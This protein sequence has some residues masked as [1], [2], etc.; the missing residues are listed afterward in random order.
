MTIDTQ[1]APGSHPDLPPPPSTVGIVGWLR[2]NLFS[3]TTNTLITV[4]ALYLLYLTLPPVFSWIFFKADFIGDSR[5]SCDSG[6][7]C[8]VFINARLSQ[9]IYGFYPEAERWRVD[10]TFY[11]LIA[12]MIPM[13]INSFRHKAWLGAFILFI[14]PV[15]GFYLLAGGSFGLATV[16][17]SLWGGLSLTLII[18]I[19]GI[20][21][22]FPI[23]LLL[24]LG[25][26]SKM[27][28][29]SAFCTG[30]IEL[31]RGVPLITV[32]FMSSVMFPLFLPDGVNFDKLIRALVGVTLFTSAYMAETVRGG[33]QA[34]PKGQYEGAEALGLN[35]WKSMSFIILPQA[36]KHVIPGI[37]GNCIGLFKDTTLVL[38]I[39]LFDFLGIVQAATTDPKWLGYAVEGYVFCAFVY[40][41]FC[42]GMSQYSQS[43]ERKLHTGHKR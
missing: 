38:I 43:V 10:S 30:F 18:S 14:Y 8:W 19:V 28:A 13:F 34:I 23:G 40:W 36:L 20:V 37:V 9:F 22:S 17:T 4:L 21:G 12:L 31:W 41:C 42:F 27:P 2:T 16:E 1:Y 26:R 7:A 32:L 35:Y 15:I 5:E 3:N 33:L 39:G 29:V 24:A 6:G 11:L 25:R